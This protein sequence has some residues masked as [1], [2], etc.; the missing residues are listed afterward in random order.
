MGRILHNRTF[1]GV[2][3]LLLA[4]SVL[5]NLSPATAN[6]P[7]ALNAHSDTENNLKQNDP[8]E[9]LVRIWTGTWT[10]SSFGR[11]NPGQPQ[12]TA[13]VA[14]NWILDLQAVD[15][16][17]NTASGT[18]TWTGKD[19]FWTYEI[20]L[21]GLTVPTAHDFIPNRTIKFDSSNTTLISPAPGGGPQ[22][23]L[24][25]E[26]FK[27]APNPSDAFYG[28]RFSIDLFPNTGIAVSAGNGFSAH[29]YN[30]ANF[31]TAVSSGTVSGST[32]VCKAGVTIS[33]VGLPEVTVPFVI[34]NKPSWHIR[35]GALGLNFTTVTPPPN[36]ICEARSNTGSLKVMGAP[37]AFGPFLTFAHSVARA[38]L[39]TFEG[40]KVAGLSTC[41]FF[42]LSGP[43]NNCLLNGAFKP[44]THYA[45][46]HTDGFTTEVNVLHLAGEP[47]ILR[48]GPLTFWVDINA[49]QLSPATTWMESVVRAAEP[50]IHKELIDH[51]PLITTY[52]IIQ[53]P[54]KVSLFVVK[55]GILGTGKSETGAAITNISRSIY[56][57]SDTNPAVILLEPDAGNY[58]VF[59][60]GISTGD[61]LL[62]VSTTKFPA[63]STAAASATG[64]ITQGNSIVYDLN[65]TDTAQG[66]TQ[67]FNTSP[68]PFPSMQLIMAAAPSP[69]GAAAA[70]DSVLQT[71]NPFPI[72]NSTNLIRGSDL[73]TRVQLLVSYV[74]LSPG[75]A[76]NAV[77]VQARDQANNVSALE[78][79]DVRDVPNTT[80][81]QVTV[82]LSEDL[83]NGPISL[84]VAL[85]GRVTDWGT[86]MIQK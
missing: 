50:F 30:K 13:P 35:Y 63:N 75:E 9:A 86:I 39:T 41:N 49:L 59:V 68:I 44:N 19:A 34:P 16:A 57:D 46:W 65:L 4:S 37:T 8:A 76:I 61:Y 38:T 42:S 64:V 85:H 20:L 62:S 48:T 54:G 81:S 28:P 58:K 15:S 32:E 26:G 5:L 7:A 72:V 77:T 66:V 82:R 33:N 29:P 51:L 78:V 36:A 25:I 83:P 71:R 43:R 2:T 1:K 80:L 40:S 55:D 17:H 70:L 53:D 52:A 69:S 31:D 11:N 23:H 6:G 12:P 79:E 27:N 14:G 73:R 84:R 10:G 22:F 45:R 3:F 56:Y 47:D 18:L 24:T 21:N 67:S 74:R 60:N